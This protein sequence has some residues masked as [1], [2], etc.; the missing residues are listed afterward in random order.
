MAEQDKPE[1]ARVSRKD[2]A[3]ATRRRIIDA[4]LARFVSEGYAATT[5]ESIAADAGVSVQTV[6]FHFGSKRN[7]LKEGV[8]ILAVGDDLP[9]PLLERPWMQELHATP[10]PARALQLWL[11]ASREIFERISPLMRIIRDAAGADPEMAAQWDT[12]R[13]QRVTAHRAL[14]EALAAKGGLREGIDV[15]AATDVLYSL[16]SPEVYGLLVGDCGW[17]P[18]RWQDLIAQLAAAA[19][20]VPGADEGATTS[21]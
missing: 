21:T 8:D 16:L 18:E 19:V 6:Y 12:N 20:L 4:S 2:Q 17:T 1:R 11:D 14:A 3:R 7:V 13:Q 15:P 5:L 10:D 9:I